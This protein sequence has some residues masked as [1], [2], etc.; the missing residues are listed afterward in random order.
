MTII[1]GFGFRKNTP[2]NS[3][4]DALNRACKGRK[5]SAIAT[6]EDKAT[7]VLFI[8]RQ[9]PIAHLFIHSCGSMNG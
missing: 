6:P 3:L 8:M 7:F 1:A 9:V 4:Y 5:I 2:L